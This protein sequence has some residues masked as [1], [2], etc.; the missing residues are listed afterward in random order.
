MRSIVLTECR[1]PLFWLWKF[2]PPHNLK[3]F[4]FTFDYLRTK[5]C[6]FLFQ[7]HGFASSSKEVTSLLQRE[8]W[9]LASVVEKEKFMFLAWGSKTVECDANY[10]DWK[11]VCVISLCQDQMRLWYSHYTVKLT[12]NC[13]KFPKHARFWQESCVKVLIAWSSLAKQTFFHRTVL[14]EFFNTV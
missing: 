11:N 13:Q 14:C 8:L 6:T 12:V 7:N 1:G 10:N 3:S 5:M 2:R 4:L 9:L